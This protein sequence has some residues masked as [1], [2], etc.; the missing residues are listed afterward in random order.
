MHNRVLAVVPPYSDQHFGPSVDDLAEGIARLPPRPHHTPLLSY[1]NTCW[2]EVRFQHR[3]TR[4]GWF[5]TGGIRHQNGTLISQDMESWL[6]TLLRQSGDFE[7]LLMDLE[8]LQPLVTRFNVVTHF[9]TAS[10]GHTPE[11]CWQLEVDELQEVM[12]RQLLNSAATEP[13]DLSDLTD[14][15]Y[16]ATLEGQPLGFPVYRLGGLINVHLALE[17]A[18][19]GPSLERFFNE[20]TES[21]LTDFHRHWF[22]QRHQRQ[23]RYGVQEL[24][25]QPYAIKA[26]SLKGHPW[27]LNTNATDMADQLRSFDKVAGFFGA[28]YF[29]L[30]AGNLVPLALAERLQEDWV[31][32]YRYISERQSLWIGK[33]LHKPYRL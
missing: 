1:L 5:R 15:L 22:F 16:P 32:D 30:V 2:P 13:L 19:N 12:D 14:P 17:I 7:Q 8:S 11:A 9:F 18:V 23:N 31:N 25:L 6:E 33:W 10:Y 27:D 4:S 20:W 28:W 3:F 24:H 21:G 29:C 26:S